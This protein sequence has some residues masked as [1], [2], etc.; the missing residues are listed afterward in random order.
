MAKSILER[1]E[2]KVFPCPMTGCWLWDGAHIPEGYGSFSIGN[3]RQIGAHRVSWV[4]HKGQ[5]P[6]GLCVL[7]RCDVRS[8]VNPNHLFL[9][10]KKDNTIDMMKKARNVP[11]FGEK[12]GCS[13]LTKEKVIQIRSSQEHCSAVAVR[14]RISETTIFDIRNRRTW[15]HI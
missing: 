11:P 7:H 5:I 3:N 10:T 8:C 9:G 14:Y 2:M 13:K 12:Q 6:N 4:L 15:K 1:F